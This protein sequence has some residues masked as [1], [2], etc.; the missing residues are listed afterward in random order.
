MTAD[1][2]TNSHLPQ[3]WPWLS[4]SLTF[5]ITHVYRRRSVAV[6]CSH[7]VWPKT[8]LTHKCSLRGCL[9]L[10]VSVCDAT[11]VCHTIVCCIVLLNWCQ[12]CVWQLT[13]CVASCLD[14]HA[15]EAPPVFVLHQENK[16]M[17]KSSEKKQNTTK[18]ILPSRFSLLNMTDIICY[19]DLNQYKNDSWY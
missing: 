18:Q 3:S 4:H 11:W 1:V 6:Y 10:G 17:V 16:R 12:Q 8:Q 5:T 9:F 19:S 15:Y 2:Q 14:A 7:G 13:S